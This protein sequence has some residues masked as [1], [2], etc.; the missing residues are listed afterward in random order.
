M[1]GDGGTIILIADDYGLGEGHDRVM[2]DLI[3][4]HAIDG[5]SVLVEL[6]SAASAEALLSL[7]E[8]CRIGL[9]L[10]LTLASQ[11]EPD[12][13]SRLK[14]LIGGLF[15]LGRARARAA[16]ETQFNMF[17]DLFGFEPEF[18]D[19]HEHC[20]SYPTLSQEVMA[21][22][23]SKNVPVRAI[24]LAAPPKG[25]KEYVLNWL[26]RRQLVE[27][28]QSGVK[29]NEYFA[30]VL[31]LDRP[32]DAIRQLDDILTSLDKKIP[33]NS[34]CWIMCHPGDAGDPMQVQGHSPA[35]RNLEAEYLRKRAN[36]R[37]SQAI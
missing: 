14:L 8:K 17:V 20:H 4:T 9:H 32:Q 29:T 21:F 1:I 18:I 19:G 16:L 23:S 24:R 2:R 30:G 27:A 13:P 37:K 26:G 28:K 35:L 36:F 15:G 6:C 3:E 31:P 10:N 7:R 25:L 22:A 33:A 11:G 12:R 34:E 5:V